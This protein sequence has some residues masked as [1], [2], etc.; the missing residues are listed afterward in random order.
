MQNFQFLASSLETLFPKCFYV[1]G[2]CLTNGPLTP[3]NVWFSFDKNRTCYSEVQLR[4]E[5]VLVDVYVRK[6]FMENFSFSWFFSFHCIRLPEIATLCTF[7]KLEQNYCLRLHRVFHK[8]A[9]V[10][11]NTN[12]SVSGGVQR[13]RNSTVFLNCVTSSRTPLQRCLC[14]TVSCFRCGTLF[15]SHKNQRQL[16]GASA[17]TIFVL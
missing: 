10:L 17:V 9:S 4:P 12:F 13:D 2:I 15:C 5:T 1:T 3:T 16:K 11:V 8:P 14:W 6:F 7:L